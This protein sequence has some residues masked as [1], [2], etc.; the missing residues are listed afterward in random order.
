MSAA[1]EEI[2]QRVV[3]AIGTPTTE[4]AVIRAYRRAG[5]LTAEARVDL[6][7]RRVGEYRAEVHRIAAADLPATIASVR[8]TRKLVVPSGIPPEWRREDVELVDDAGLSAPELDGVDGALTGCTVAIAETGTIVLTAGPLE[9]R[10]ALTLVPDLHVCVVREAQ[11]VELVPEALAMIV[12]RPART[13][14]DHVRLRPVGDLGHRA[15]PSRRRPRPPRPRRPRRQGVAMT[16]RTAFV[17]RVRPEKIDEY[18]SAH[19]EVWPEMLDALRGAGIRN[20]TIFRDDNR[21]FGY[22]EADDLEA[23]GRYLAQQEVCTR[24]QDAMA[25]LL[26][27]RVPDAGP[28]PLE[29]VFRLD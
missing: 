8:G 25:D 19:R 3:T 2:L 20:Y 5:T 24:W 12:A 27:E 1:R 23:A 9:G 15:Q 28:P 4:T 29:E 21:M 10:R 13:P 14:A 18:V 6:F 11:I 16:Q 7:C 22:F 26:D 17:L